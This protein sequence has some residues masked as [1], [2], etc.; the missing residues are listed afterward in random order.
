MNKED[1]VEVTDEDLEICLSAIA[2]AIV[3]QKEV[4]KEFERV[5]Q[6]S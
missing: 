4:I 5:K 3:A 2:D 1:V 6:L